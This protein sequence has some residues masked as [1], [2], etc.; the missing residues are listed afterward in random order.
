MHLNLLFVIPFLPG[1]VSSECVLASEFW[2]E[3]TFFIWVMDGP[4]RFEYVEERA[5]PD[6]VEKL[7]TNPLIY[8]NII[9]WH[10]HYLRH[11][12]RW[13]QQYYCLFPSRVSWYLIPRCRICILDCSN[14]YYIGWDQGILKLI[15]LLWWSLICPKS[16]RNCTAL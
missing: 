14:F 5:E 4:F 2:W 3:S 11:Q 15:V 10:R 16:G 8:W 12:S 6:R 7:R 9:H 1:S 13:P